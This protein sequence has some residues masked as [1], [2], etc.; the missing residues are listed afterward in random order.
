MLYSIRTRLT[1]TFLALAVGPLLIVGLLLASNTYNVQTQEAIALQREMATHL[2]FRVQTLIQ[3]LESAMD[4]LVRMEDLLKL[5]PARQKLMLSIFQ[6]QHSAIDDLILLDADGRVLSYQ[7]R[8][9]LNQDLPTPSQKESESFRVPISQGVTYF[10]PVRFDER[11]GEPVMIIAVPII[12]LDTNQP[13]GVL[14][15]DVRLK[16]IWD[17]VAHIRPGQQGN[18]FIVDAENRVVAHSNPSVVL[19]GTH[20]VP[21]DLDGVQMGLN[22]QSSVL[23]S[24][25]ISFGAQQFHIVVEG[26]VSEALAPAVHI[27]Y[28]TLTVVVIALLVAGG[29]GF[30]MVRRIVSPIEEI[31][32]TARAINAG[33]LSRRV[34][35]RSHDELGVLADAFNKMTL[36]LETLI[37]DLEKQVAKRTAQLE[38]A[39]KE[40]EAFAYSVSHDL[41]APLRHINGF[42]E[43]LKE[44]TET[45]VDEQGKHSMDVISNSTSRMGAM[46]DDLLSF[47]RMSRSEM[48]RAQVDLV[49]LVQDVIREFELETTNREIEWQISPLPKITGDRAMIRMAFENLIG[50]ALKF[51]Q[52]RNLAKIEIG[53]RQGA[54]AENVIFVRDNGVGFDMHYA[55]KLFG[56]FQRLHRADEF[57]G[58]GIGLA[59]VRRIIERH[60]GR[61]WAEAQPGQGATFYFSLPANHVMSKEITGE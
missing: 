55:D 11:S 10:G 17:L 51:T 56:V 33:D 48:S 30:L 27:V 24:Q 42:L 38:A 54:D 60:G 59:N 25:V 40:L 21:P 44:C 4:M 28:I 45:V 14:V 46:I 22:G 29:F 7:S 34:V 57:E 35:V 19:R 52:P 36:Q 6:S 1:I 9:K 37:N 2:F 39:N 50:N 3:N 58:T 53:W 5:E 26:P 15:A 49:S 23:V 13:E 43:I 20:Y 31:A 12:A 16:E 18:S 61:T 32:E 47:S 8:L 41:R